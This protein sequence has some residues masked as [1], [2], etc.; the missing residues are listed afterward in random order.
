MTFKRGDR[1]TGRLWLRGVPSWGSRICLSLSMYV[2]IYIY[3]SL[4]FYVYLHLSIY[5]ILVT[6]VE[7]RF[8]EWQFHSP[9]TALGAPPDLVVAHIGG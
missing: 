6:C 1:A 7:D 2:C 8:F 4:L 9:F 5:L 3:L